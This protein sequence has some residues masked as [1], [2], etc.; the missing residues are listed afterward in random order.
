MELNQPNQ[1]PVIHKKLIFISTV[2]KVSYTSED[3]VFFFFFFLL[4]AATRLVLLVELSK[5]FRVD[6]PRDEVLLEEDASP[7]I[8]MLMLESGVYPSL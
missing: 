2:A 8:S 1:A 4:E 5:R 6:S 7:S 3:D